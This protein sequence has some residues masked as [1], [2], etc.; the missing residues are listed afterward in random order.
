MQRKLA[1]SANFTSQVR[2]VAA[3]W[4]PTHLL[5]PFSSK[6]V[7][8]C[9]IGFNTIDRCE[10]FD[11]ENIIVSLQKHFPDLQLV[12][13]S[14]YR[15]TSQYENLKIFYFE[16]EKKNGTIFSLV[17]QKV[18]KNNIE[19]DEKEQY[20]AART[21]VFMNRNVEE[22][23]KNLLILSQEI[24]SIHDL[25]QVHINLDQH[26]GK[27]IVFHVILVQISPFHP[28]SLK[29][30]LF[31]CSIVSERTTPVRKIEGRPIHAEISAFLSAR[32][33][34]FAIGRLS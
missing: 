22:V 27:E 1:T 33:L 15:H 17:E 9:L 6:P 4:I 32:P 26:L 28:F 5:F 25:P 14:Y 3:G 31:G 34:S 8:G 30:R 2:H 16:V 13:E 20:P 11:E 29:E 10:L 19:E 7:L 24:H 12:K 23:Y 18:L 21:S